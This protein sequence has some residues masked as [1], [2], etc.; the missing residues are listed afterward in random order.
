MNASSPRGSSA[1]SSTITG[2]G[3]SPKPLDIL[4]QLGRDEY[5]MPNQPMTLP[6][7]E[8]TLNPNAPDFTSRSDLNPKRLPRRRRQ[9]WQR[10]TLPP[11]AAVR[12]AASTTTGWSRTRPGIRVVRRAQPPTIPRGASR[13]FRPSARAGHTCTP[14]YWC[15]TTTHGHHA[16]PAELQRI[17]SD[18]RRQPRAPTR[19]YKHADGTGV[20]YRWRDWEL[21][22]REPGSTRAAPQEAPGAGSFLNPAMMG[23]TGTIPVATVGVVTPQQRQYQGAS[24]MQHQHSAS[25]P[26]SANPTPSK[27]KYL[28]LHLLNVQSHNGHLAS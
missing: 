5:S 26:G 9:R 4:S 15:T 13:V 11:G 2:G 24:P 16:E 17:A 6:R 21:R 28:V 1:S 25:A 14:T 8:S 22:G 3:Q 18:G 19:Q 23:A 27:G 10:L 12:H 20:H 7:I